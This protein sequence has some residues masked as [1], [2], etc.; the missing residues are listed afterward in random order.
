LPEFAGSC[1]ADGG[2][3]VPPPKLPELDGRC[4]G[5]LG[6]VDEL[7]RCEKPP[8]AAGPPREKPPPPPR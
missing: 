6:R 8:L 1:E 4:E 3:E 5:V 2:R 7:G